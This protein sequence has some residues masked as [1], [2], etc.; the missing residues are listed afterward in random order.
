MHLHKDIALAAG[1]VIGRD[2]RIVPKNCQD[3][4]YAQSRGSVTVGVVTDGCGSG[5]HTEVGA[6]IGARIVGEAVLAER[7]RVSSL[8]EIRWDRILGDVTSTLRVL[9]RQMGDSLNAIVNEYFLFTVVGVVMDDIEAGFFNFG[10]GVVLVN[11]QQF[12][13]GPFPNN[14]PPYLGYCLVGSS[15]QDQSLQNLTFQVVQT[16][17]LA[18]LEY[19]LIGTD[20][21]MD[22]MQLTGNRKPGSDEPIKPIREF[23][24]DRC[25]DNEVL[26]SR[27]LLLVARDWHRRDSV[28]NQMVNEPGLLPDDTTMLVGKR[29]PNPA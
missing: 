13:L 3:G 7:A 2:H 5:A 20:G 16:V 8:S 23:V 6:Q 21:V 19:F 24:D 15:L 10:D 27:R 12:E 29:I 1:S 4:Y 11:D 18:E 9:A 25:F 14:Q 26:L 28:T 22:L 17:P